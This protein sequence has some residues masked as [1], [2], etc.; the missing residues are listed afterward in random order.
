MAISDQTL[1]PRDPKAPL[2]MR[3]FIDRVSGI[4]NSLMRKER[5]RL[6]GQ[7]EWDL[8]AVT[9]SEILVK[10]LTVDGPG[11]GLNAD[12]LD[13]LDSTAFA[14]VGSGSIVIGADVSGGI[15]P[16]VLFVGAGPVLAQDAAF[17]W[18]GTKLVLASAMVS[19]SGTEPSA[20]AEGYI[21]GPYLKGIST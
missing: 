9:A 3:T 10:L 14:L 11:S 20:P 8:D 17:Q 21:E 4:L 12:L 2:P 1:V 15:T 7:G 6:E 16:R 13:G 19:S 18:S 5:I